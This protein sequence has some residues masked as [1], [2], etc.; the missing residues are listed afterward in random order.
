MT[1]V[2]VGNAGFLLEPPHQ[3]F[4]QLTFRREM[5]VDRSFADARLLGNL[6]SREIA[7]IPAA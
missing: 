6:A 1:N 7:P 2:L 5:T 3:R 4:V